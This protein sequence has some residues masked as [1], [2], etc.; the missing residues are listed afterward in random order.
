MTHAILDSIHH[1]YLEDTNPDVAA[2]HEGF[3]DIVALL[4]RFTFRDLVEHEIYASGGRLDRYTVFGELATQF[5]EALMGNRGALRSMI[6]RWNDKQVWEPLKPNP[7]DYATVMEAHDRGALLVA[8]VFDAFQR[9]YVYR[10][11]DLIRIASGGTGVLPDGNINRDLCHRLALEAAQIAEHLLHICIR[12]LDY[13]TPHDISFGDYLRALISADLDVAPEDEGGYR[14][15]LIEAFRARGIFPDRVNTL[16]IE[17][18]RWTPP[19]FTSRQ[20][21]TFQ[22]IAEQLRGP[23]RALVDVADREKLFEQ[24]AQAQQL[25]HSLLN[26]KRQGLEPVSGKRFSTSWE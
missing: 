26:G 8:T 12:A 11:R 19:D 9:I 2:F 22:W 6:G 13:T 24:S 1:R 7:A 18:L 5:G 21:R 25:L 10:T 23:I 4:Q 14:V 3:A 20:Q 16:S 15:A 17:S